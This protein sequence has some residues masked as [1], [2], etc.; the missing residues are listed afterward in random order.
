M[1][2]TAV[3]R[4]RQPRHDPPKGLHIRTVRSPLPDAR[5]GRLDASRLEF[6]ATVAHELRAPLTAIEGYAEMLAESEAPG[7]APEQ[8]RML[9]AINRRPVQLRNLVDDLLTLS[10]LETGAAAIA[11]G[12]ID[13]TQAL[14][15]AAEAIVPSVT[16]GG[17]TLTTKLPPQGTTI[18]GDAAQLDRGLLNL[19]SNAI[20]YTPA[21]GTISLQASATAS[22]AVIQVADSG[23]GIPEPDQDKLFTRFYRASNVTSSHVPATGLGLAIVAGII[24]QHHGTIRLSSA[25]GAGTTVTVQLPRRSPA[26]LAGPGSAAW[27]VLRP[28]TVDT[29]T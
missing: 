8:A 12:T 24:A 27:P 28:G 9:T 17:L 7:L 15:D 23:I 29:M 6:F 14:S 10:K 26:G 3:V 16:A 2:R 1:V 13:L 25:E 21:G 5:S 4:R 20:T 18:E 11:V 22:S 19:L